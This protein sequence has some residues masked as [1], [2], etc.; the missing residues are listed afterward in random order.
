MKSSRRSFIKN[1]SALC[2]SC[3]STSLLMQACA[4]INPIVEF[5]YSKNTLIIKTELLD[6]LGFA[7]IEPN[8][9]PA[10]ILIKKS[11]NMYE[12]LLMLC[13]HKNCELN[14]IG[15]QLICP[16]HGSEFDFNGNVLSGPA[17]KEL[18][19]FK[20]HFDNQNIYISKK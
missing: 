12:A 16:C 11:N 4:S 20:I 15:K 9:Y 6:N 8:N 1:S 18:Y 2:V 14:L 17:D 13:T 19:Q 5:K 3:F 10:P 7:I